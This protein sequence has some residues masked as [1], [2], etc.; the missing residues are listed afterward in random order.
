METVYLSDAWCM[1]GFAFFV[2]LL[3]GY[4]LFRGKDN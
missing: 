1:F 3:F 4:F 2:G